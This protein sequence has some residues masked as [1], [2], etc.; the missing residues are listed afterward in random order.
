MTKHS[1]VFVP[2]N[3]VKGSSSPDVK[4]Q[5]ESVGSIAGAWTLNRLLLYLEATFLSPDVKKSAYWCG[6]TVNT[7]NRV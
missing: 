2:D 3:G 4:Y 5:P 7:V 6:L 1:Q